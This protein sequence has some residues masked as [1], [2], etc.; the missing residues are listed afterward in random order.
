[1]TIIF[2]I[3]TVASLDFLTEG[4]E[5]FAS[6]AGRVAFFQVQETA[7]AAE[8]NFEGLRVKRLQINAR[9]KSRR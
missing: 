1:V 6:E 9:A 5:H 4:I 2:L 8:G 3:V 7:T